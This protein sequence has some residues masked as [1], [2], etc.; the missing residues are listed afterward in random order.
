MN[1]LPWIPLGQMHCPITYKYTISGPFGLSRQRID[2]NT[3]LDPV[4][5]D[6][7]GKV[8]QYF[9]TASLAL[10]LTDSVRLEVFT[11]STPAFGGLG[12]IVFP[13]N[14]T[15]RQLGTP[16]DGNDSPCVV[17]LSG[18]ADKWGK[19][20]MHFPGAP[21]R[22]ITDR[23][24]NTD[25]EA[26][27]LTMARILLLGMGSFMYFNPYGIGI[28]HPGT[29][30]RI[31]SGPPVASWRHFNYARVCSMTGQCPQGGYTT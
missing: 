12:G 24:L 29:S 27:M 3:Y 31:R 23:R 30:A 19:R 18:H 26:H 14:V 25:G 6:H 15:G 8:G 17:L 21:A 16:C 2:V 11:W 1:D 22:W 9:W 7:L 4:D 10:A 28:I 13:Q 20:R 5:G